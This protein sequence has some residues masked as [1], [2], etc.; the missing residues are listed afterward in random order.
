MHPNI[1]PRIYPQPYKQTL[2]SQG[3]AGLISCNSSG[4][5]TD[6]QDNLVKDHQQY[7]QGS[8]STVWEAPEKIKIIII[9]VPGLNKKEIQI[10]QE[11]EFLTCVNF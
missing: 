9:N 10:L 5:S 3:S 8:L 2:M 11:N 1:N 7:P 4:P 6:P